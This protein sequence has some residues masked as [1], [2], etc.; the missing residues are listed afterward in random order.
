MGGPE[1]LRVEV[2]GAGFVPAQLAVPRNHPA[3]ITF[4]RMTDKTCGT[5]VVFPRL[6]RGYDLPL[7]KEVT[8]ELSAAD[9]ADTLKFNCS[10]DMLHGMLVAK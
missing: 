8:V 3:V 1:R 10:M 6:H 5:D 7:H 9:I 4:E 2:T